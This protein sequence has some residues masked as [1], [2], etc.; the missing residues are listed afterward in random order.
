MASVLHKYVSGTLQDIKANGLASARD[1]IAALK[2][3]LGTSIDRIG[4]G[5]QQNCGYAAEIRC[6]PLTISKTR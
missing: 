1:K 6:F 5:L 3:A 4:S 2:K